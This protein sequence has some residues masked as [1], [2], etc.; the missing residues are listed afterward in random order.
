MSMNRVEKLFLN[1]GDKYKYIVHYENLELYKNL[2]LLIKVMHRSIKFQE[3]TWLKDYID[4]NTDLRARASNE[5]EKD[6]FKLMNNCIFGRTMG[7]IQKS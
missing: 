7:N 6:F 3:R 4:L 2:G 5:F 1:L